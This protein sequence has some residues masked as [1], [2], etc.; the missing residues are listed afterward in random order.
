MQHESAIDFEYRY[1]CGKRPSA[2]GPFRR[3]PRDPMYAI[4]VAF[5]CMVSPAFTGGTYAW[6][7]TSWFHFSAVATGIGAAELGAATVI[8]VGCWLGRSE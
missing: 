8:A 4:G 5:L 3:P 6:G 2:R 1:D 7:A